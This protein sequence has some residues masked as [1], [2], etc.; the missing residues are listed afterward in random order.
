MKIMGALLVTVN[1]LYSQ[2][3]RGGGP[4]E[5][6]YRKQKTPLKDRTSKKQNEGGSGSKK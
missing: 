4:R 2:P 5:E 6:K 3:R 1:L